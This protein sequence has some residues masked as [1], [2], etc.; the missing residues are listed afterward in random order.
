MRR[1]VRADSGTDFGAESAEGG[2]ATRAGGS[3]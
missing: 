1:K 2:A 3:E